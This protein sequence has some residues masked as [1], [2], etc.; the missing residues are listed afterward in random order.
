[1]TILTAREIMLVAVLG[2]SVFTDMYWGKV[3]NAVVM[4]AMLLGLA[5]GAMLNGWSGLA[6]SGSGLL[7]GGGLLVIP[8]MFGVMGG[9]DVK[10]AAAVGA[11]SGTLFVLQALAYAFVLAAAVALLVRMAQGRLRELLFHCWHILSRKMPTSFARNDS[12]VRGLS[13]NE[14]GIPFAACLAG[15]VLGAKWIDFFRLVG[16]T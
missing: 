6:V 7:V 11:L 13:G 5:F 9:G 8:F 12:E 1:M 14:R 3:F 4:P 10:L 15:G 2:A 16:A